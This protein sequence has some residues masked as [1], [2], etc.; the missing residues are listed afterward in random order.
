VFQGRFPLLATDALPEWL[1]GVAAWDKWTKV[2]AFVDIFK[3]LT[4]SLDLRMQQIV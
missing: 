2:P 4:F 3:I 1:E